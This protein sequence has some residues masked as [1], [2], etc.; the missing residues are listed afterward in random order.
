VGP[1][2]TSLRS[3]IQRVH[4]QSRNICLDVFNGDYDALLELSRSSMATEPI[5][6]PPDA[7]ARLWRYALRQGWEV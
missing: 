4:T 2:S 6:I 1:E 7:L 3:Q 5:E